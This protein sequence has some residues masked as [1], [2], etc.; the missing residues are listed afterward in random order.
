MM[1]KSGSRIVLMDRAFSCWFAGVGDFPTG[2]VKSAGIRQV[3]GV[4][5]LGLISPPQSRL[6][7]PAAGASGAAFASVTSVKPQ[8]QRSARE[9]E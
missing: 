3:I 7:Y 4:G 1:L 9:K 2:V 6:V 5:Q 8:R